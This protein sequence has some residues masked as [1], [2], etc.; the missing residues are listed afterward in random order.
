LVRIAYAADLPTPDEVIRSL[1]S[2]GTG[3]G[4][5]PRASAQGSAP[6][7]ASSAGSAM[8]APR[9]VS[10][11]SA[12]GSALQASAPRSAPVAERTQPAPGVRLARF[13]DLVAL[14]TEKRDVALKATLLRDV[15]LVHF[16]DG[17]IDI[18][19][20]RTAPHTLVGDLN[21]KLL[22]WT[23]KRWMISISNEKGAPTLH[24]QIE[25]KKEEFREGVMAEPLVRSVLDR[26]PGAEVVAVRMA[27]ALPV[28]GEGA[29]G[30]DGAPDEMPDLDD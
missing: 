12:I 1:Q 16:E 27:E 24:S 4:A 23:G 8:S 26:F 22:E 20:E 2:D 13:E 25:A 28:L 17:R 29:A 30:L 14:A 7:G 19:L 6:S 5:A 15:R 11:G 9:A 10:R 18:A 3:G 21:K